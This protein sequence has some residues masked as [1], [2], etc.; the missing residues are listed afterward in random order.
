MKVY[1]VWC[2]YDLEWNLTENVS[3]YRTEKKMIE[4]LESKDW[5]EVGY[6]NWEAAREAGMLDVE[7]MWL[8][9]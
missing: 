8:N 2:E 1:K 3:M 5:D 6:D 7:A 9:W 4:N